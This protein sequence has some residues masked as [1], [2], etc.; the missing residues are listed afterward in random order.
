MQV[1]YEFVVQLNIDPMLPR[2]KYQLSTIS[3]LAYLWIKRRLRSDAKKNIKNLKV[4]F[5]GFLRKNLL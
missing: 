5:F 4:S 3:V 1:S 2:V